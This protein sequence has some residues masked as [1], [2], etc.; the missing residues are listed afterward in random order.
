MSKTP[1]AEAL[2]RWAT[3]D[4]ARRIAAITIG[5]IKPD[6]YHQLVSDI[7]AAIDAGPQGECTWTRRPNPGEG[8][9]QS[10]GK[11]TGFRTIRICEGCGK[12]VAEALKG[13]DQ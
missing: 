2:E 3:M 6:A 1:S 5:K 4:E 10:C 12:K 7:A 13:V 8:Y 9:A 11:E